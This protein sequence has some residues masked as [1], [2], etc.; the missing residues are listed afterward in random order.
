MKKLH[1]LILIP[2]ALVWLWLGCAD[3]KSPLPSVSHPN[4]WAEMSVQDNHGAKVREAGLVS[5]AEC[6][7]KDYRGGASKVSCFKCH[8]DYPHGSDWMTADNAGSH[9]GYVAQKNFDLRSCQPCHGADY[10]GGNGKESCFK[11]HKSY[12]HAVEWLTSGNAKFHGAYVQGQS[13][14]MVECQ[15]CHGEDFKGGQGK[16]SCFKCHASYPHDQNWLTASSDRSHGNY[17]AAQNWSMTA[18]QQCHGADLAGGSGKEPCTKCHNQYPHA[19]GWIQAGASSFH[20]A[21]LKNN[22]WQ[23]NQCANCHGPDYTAGDSK[24]SCGRCH[25]SYPHSQDW[26]AAGALAFHG[27]YIRGNNWSMDECKTCHGADYRGGVTDQSCRTCHTGSEGPETCNLCH[28]SA[29]NNAPP[30]ALNGASSVTEMGVGQHQYHV[31]ERMYSCDLCH[32][33]PQKFGSPGHIDAVANAEVLGLWKWDRARGM[34]T[35]G[36]HANNPGRNY[37]WNHP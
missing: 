5:C 3:E 11:C 25:D 10:Q 20:G 2:S 22:N 21:W 15:V 1:F 33:T 37:V 18:C 14:D 23:L 4:N 27:Q 32:V 30:K 19:D 31:T 9:G 12:P 28:G 6:H 16:E 29:V 35:T 26:T 36:C 24:K 13:Y 34:C 8:E 7:G 17:L